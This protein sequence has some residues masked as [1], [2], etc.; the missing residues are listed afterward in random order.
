MYGR[1]IAGIDP[2]QQDQA[3]NSSSLGSIFIFDTLTQRIVAEYTGRPSTARDFYEI[4]RKLIMLY[5]AKA[6][7]EN[8]IVGLFDYF[9]FQG[10]V[11]LLA[12]K[13]KF[14]D[15]IIKSSTV[16]RKKGMHMAPQLK[17]YGEE[18]IKMWLIGPS[19]EEG[20]SNLYTIRSIPLLKELI[21]YDPDP[22]K[23][24]DRVMSLMMCLY[25]AAD[26]KKIKALL[27]ETEDEGYDAF[28]RHDFFN[29]KSGDNQNIRYT[30][31]PRGPFFDYSA[32]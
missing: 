13:P 25:Y 11:H 1:Y 5:N 30:P 12:D 31:K 2:Y 9:Q 21:H 4:C 10:C 17:E 22:K 16:S 14:V 29:K 27:E 28:F 23:N 32:I 3:E 7:Y 19:T 6:L 8:Q 18:L 15:D 20:I 24:F 26:K